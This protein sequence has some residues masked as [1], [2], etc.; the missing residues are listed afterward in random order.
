IGDLSQRF[1]K[2]DPKPGHGLQNARVPC[3]GLVLG[4]HH[5]E[6]RFEGRLSATPLQSHLGSK[7]GDR[8]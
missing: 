8:K 1:D 4:Y 6:R 2:I 7:G 3:N 5:C